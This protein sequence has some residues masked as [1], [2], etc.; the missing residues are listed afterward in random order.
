MRFR[1]HCVTDLCVPM[2]AV[3][4]PTTRLYLVRIQAPEFQLFLKQWSA[5]VCGVV[6][7]PRPETEH[8]AVR[9]DMSL[10]R[11]AFGES[12]LDKL[13]ILWN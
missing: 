13:T 8:C 11:A 2:N 1:P 7:L 4:A 9:G 3:R 5:Y 12:A 6:Q 10:E